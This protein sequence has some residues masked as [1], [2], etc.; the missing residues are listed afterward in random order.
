MRKSLVSCESGR[1]CFA[2]FVVFGK[3]FGESTNLLPCYSGAWS[4]FVSGRMG[5]DG[6][7]HA[8]FL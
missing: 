1:R 3:L 8:R 2:G 7:V 6:G 5:S 4:V